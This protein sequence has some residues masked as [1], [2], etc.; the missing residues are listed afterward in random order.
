M[1]LINEVT[2]FSIV[3][4]LHLRCPHCKMSAPVGVPALYIAIIHQ[5][6]VECVTC[7]KKF[8]VNLT[9]QIRADELRNEADSGAECPYCNGTKILLNGDEERT[10]WH[11][12]DFEQ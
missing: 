3:A 7:K 11:C 1:S 6:E 12:Y 2:G 9:C 5:T 4:M 10:C 8:Y